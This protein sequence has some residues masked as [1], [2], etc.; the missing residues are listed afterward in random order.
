MIHEV[1]GLCGWAAPYGSYGGA[2]G[3]AWLSRG[4][5]GGCRTRERL[6]ERL[7]RVAGAGG[8]VRGQAAVKGAGEW[9]WR[10]WSL[11]RRSSAS[12]GWTAVGRGA[13]AAFRAAEG[14]D[15]LAVQSWWRTSAER[16]RTRRA[17]A[18][19]LGW[20]CGRRGCQKFNS[21]CAEQQRGAAAVAAGL[22]ARGCWTEQRAADGVRPWLWEVAAAATGAS[23][24]GRNGCGLWVK[25]REAGEAMA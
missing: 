8:R 1:R 13:A 16:E 15:E 22:R 9:G 4:A 20:S 6:R 11:E 5:M 18:E 10:G 3:C 19:R 24:A 23:V 12:C 7:S 14:G 25:W 17:A 2:L 21:A